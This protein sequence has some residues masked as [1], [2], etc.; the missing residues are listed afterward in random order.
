MLTL[1]EIQVLQSLWISITST[2]ID[3]L[4]KMLIHYGNKGTYGYCFLHKPPACYFVEQ[5]VF[6]NKITV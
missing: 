6:T 2:E 5:I 4:P 1:T 3:C